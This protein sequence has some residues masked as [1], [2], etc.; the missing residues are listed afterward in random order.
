MRKLH[1]CQS[2]SFRVKWTVSGKHSKEGRKER[3]L[4]RFIFSATNHPCEGVNRYMAEGWM[5]LCDRDRT[6]TQLQ[7]TDWEPR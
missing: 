1:I 3:S 6:R 2:L 4:P 5:L 7:L